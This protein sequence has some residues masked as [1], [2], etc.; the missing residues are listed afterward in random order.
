MFEK[1]LLFV[2][3]KI[4]ISSVHSGD[5]S[6]TSKDATTYTTFVPLTTSNDISKAI[7]STTLNDDSKTSAITGATTALMSDISTVDDV[8]QLNVVILVFFFH[9]FCVVF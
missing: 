9:I 4:K 7:D 3:K 2:E 5:T 8:V 1:V 6:V